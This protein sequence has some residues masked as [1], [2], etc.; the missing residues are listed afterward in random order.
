[1][2]AIAIRVWFRRGALDRRLARGADPS[3][4]EQ[5]A[6][7]A[8]QLTSRRTR[9][10]L[11]EG[12]LNLLEAAEAPQRSPTAAVPLQRRAILAERGLLLTIAED[13]RGEGE[14]SPRGVALVEQLLTDGD[15]P[16]YAPQAVIGAVHDALIHAHAALHLS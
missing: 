6:R 2:D 16:F 10:G 1:M 9:R 13:L 3:E 7:R 15:S 4:C 11:A 12:I 8:R 5:L 14:L